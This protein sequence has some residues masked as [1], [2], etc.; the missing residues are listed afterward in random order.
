MKKL[1]SFLML[2]FCIFN[3]KIVSYAD[4]VDK[5]NEL[6]NEDIEKITDALD[7]YEL[8]TGIPVTFYLYN[9]KGE[10]E[11]SDIASG[12]YSY[13][14]SKENGLIIL[15][16]SIDELMYIEPGLNRKDLFTSNM[17]EEMIQ[18]AEV[19]LKNGDYLTGIES[20]LETSKLEIPVKVEDENEENIGVLNYILQVLFMIVC[21]FIGALIIIYLYICFKEL[22]NF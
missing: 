4:V 20:M 15:Y 3:C 8:E 22:N 1:I 7:K 21:I 12:L 19:D 13:T 18:S 14:F 2:C 5:S 16:Y 11:I 6:S 17:C 9:T 10:R